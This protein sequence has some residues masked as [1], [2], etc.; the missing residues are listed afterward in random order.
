MDPSS[1][2]GDPTKE[3]SRLMMTLAILFVIVGVLIASRINQKARA[4]ERQRTREL[5]TALR[6]SES[7]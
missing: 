2:G 1:R 3:T 5:E 7:K 4:K 6:R